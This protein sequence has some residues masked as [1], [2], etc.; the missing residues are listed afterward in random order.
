[1]NIV[2]EGRG[3]IDDSKTVSGDVA[4]TYLRRCLTDNCFECSQLYLSEVLQRHFVCQCSCHNL[5]GGA[6]GTENRCPVALDI[7]P[8]GSRRFNPKT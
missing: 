3:F 7:E 4:V 2:A 1:M 5:T 8:A 6:N